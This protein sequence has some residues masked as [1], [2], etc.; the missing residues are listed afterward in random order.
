[1]FVTAGT[2]GR[3]DGMMTGEKAKFQ[4]AVT[5]PVG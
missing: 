2:A 5:F 3:W 1:M 4:I